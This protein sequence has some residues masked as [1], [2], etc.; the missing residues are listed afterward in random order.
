MTVNKHNTLLVLL[1]LAAFLI[2]GVGIFV[3]S[4]FSKETPKVSQPVACQ[5]DNSNTE[6]HENIGKLTNP[7]LLCDTS[8]HI[9]TG[10][11]KIFEQNY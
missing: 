1:V 10:E 7:L 3:G 4:F 9:E 8:T 11:F 5:N 2:F 6:I